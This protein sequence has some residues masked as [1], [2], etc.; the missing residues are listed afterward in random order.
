MHGEATMILPITGVRCE[1]ACL[2]KPT[3][4]HLSYNATH[5]FASERYEYFGHHCGYFGHYGLGAKP[6]RA[7]LPGYAYQQRFAVRLLLCLAKAR[8][9]AQQKKKGMTLVFFMK[10]RTQGNSGSVVQVTRSDEVALRRLYNREY[11]ERFLNL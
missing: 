7:R 2:Y 1:C 3:R 9:K 4:S 8:T 6:S 11:R 10:V 5:E